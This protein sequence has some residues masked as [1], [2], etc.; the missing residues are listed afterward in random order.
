MNHPG[1]FN[2]QHRDLPMKQIF[3]L[4]LTLLLA[5]AC[6]G[7]SGA[8]NGFSS[9]ELTKMNSGD[10][11]ARV[12]L[13]IMDGKLKGTHV[14]NKI[15]P[16]KSNRLIQIGMK[17]G[18]GYKDEV[19]KPG[20]LFVG[21]THA[22]NSD[23]FLINMTK[24]FVGMIKEGSFPSDGKP[25]KITIEN[26]GENPEWLRTYGEVLSRNDITFTQVGDWLT[27]KRNNEVRLVEGY[28]TEQVEFGY[29]DRNEQ[30]AK[31][32]VDVK[33]TFSLYETYRPGTSD[34][35]R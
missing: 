24:N 4:L 21:T 10:F 11:D 18:P 25:W 9:E 12:T 19:T 1:F 31:E 3:T 28:Y 2:Q 35:A 7:N 13:E 14:F 5:T 27:I 33:V 32:T 22:E 16:E 6:G 34:Q 26:K 30:I 8:D 20:S 17:K 15:S 29:N 23:Y